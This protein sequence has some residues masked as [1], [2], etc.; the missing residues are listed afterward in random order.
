MNKVF[1]E[2]IQYLYGNQ[3]EG[4]VMT[5]DR[6]GILSLKPLPESF[7]SLPDGQIWIGNTSNVATPR[8]PSGDVTIS[9]TGV[10]TIKTSVNLAGSPTTTTQSPGDNSTKIATTAFVLANSVLPALPDGEIWIGNGSNVATGITPSGDATISDTGVITI[11]TSVNISGNPTTT[12]QTALTN[13]TIIATTA[14]VDAAASKSVG[15]IS[16]FGVKVGSVTGPVPPT[17]QYGSI[18]IPF[19]GTI[20]GWD[21]TAYGT[22]PTCTFDV[23]KVASGTV[24]PTVANSIINTGSGGAYPALAT[25]NVIRSTNVA[26]WTTTVSAGDVIIFNLN[27]VSVAPFITL[28]IELTRT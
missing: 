19:N 9:D 20:T 13:N 4:L 6:N 27:A 23:W 22:S 14:Y 28:Q 7:P 11:K 17:G 8:T 1:T 26:H 12:T 15:L 18:I 24:L 21:I 16:N 2:A 25:G 10:M 3:G 5:S